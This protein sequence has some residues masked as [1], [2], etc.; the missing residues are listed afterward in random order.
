MTS[1]TD[2]LINYGTIYY[3]KISA[4]NTAGESPLSVEVNVS[5]YTLP[6]TPINFTATPIIGK[7]ILNWRPPDS[8]GGNPIQNYTIYRSTSS[9]NE[10]LYFQLGN[11][12]ALQIILS[13]MEQFIITKYR[14]ITQREKVS[15]SGEVSV[16]SYILPNAPLNL[17]ATPVIGQ[18]TL[19]WSPPDSNGGNP[20]QNYT[21][22]RS[23]SIEDEKFYV[24]LG[25]VTNFTDDN[26]IFGLIYYY[27]VSANN[28]GGESP[29]SNEINSTTL[30]YD[31][32][33]P[34]M[35]AIIPNPN[36]VGNVSITWSAVEGAVS[37]NV[38][39]MPTA[40]SSLVGIEP[41]A[42]VVNTFFIDTNLPNGTYYYAV[43]A[44][45]ASG[46]SILSN[47]QS[48]IVIVI[49]SSNINP[50]NQAA[51][52]IWEQAWF[53]SALGAIGTFL[54]VIITRKRYHGNPPTNPPTNPPSNP[55]PTPSI[56]P[57]TNITKE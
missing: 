18:I 21:I 43:T 9:G 45:N 13:I 46:A 23:S 28:T 50:P 15:F 42:S 25:N 11:V 30:G 29:L 54:G 1:F 36:T 19:T 32:S 4:N 51:S 47:F 17:T 12:T 41:I 48:V 8:N 49:L 53:W 35:S 7:I 22:Y 6:N 33:P 31:P 37:Y 3:Y 2:N 24:S 34:L 16:S 10:I 38:Y 20:I 52:P 39:R 26:V 27:K 40:F 57:S 56:N 14:L 5:S 44:V 55:S